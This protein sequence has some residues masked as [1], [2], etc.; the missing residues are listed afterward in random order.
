[1]AEQLI[2]VEVAYAKP[3]EQ[4]IL[5]LKVPEGASVEQAIKASGLLA[6]FPEIEPSEIKAGIFGNVCRMDQVL[7][8]ADRVEI[9][10][11]LFHDPKEA[12]RQRAAKG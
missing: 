4:V 10:R 3:E 11:P 2:D 1:M 6:R 8:Q 7:K 9:Y 5:S 12:R